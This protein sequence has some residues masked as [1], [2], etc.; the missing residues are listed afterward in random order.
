M[1]LPNFKRILSRFIYICIA[2]IFVQCEEDE[3]TQSRFNVTFIDTRGGSVNQSSGLFDKGTYLT[4]EAIPDENFCF[5]NWSGSIDSDENPTSLTVFKELSLQPNFEFCGDAVY[6]DE[7]GITIKAKE[8]ALIGGTGKINGVVYTIISEEDLRIKIENGEDLSKY[9]TSLVT[10]MSG[11]FRSS[12]GPEQGVEE[13][14]FDIN[15]WDV[16]NVTDM[17]SMFYRYRN[18]KGLDHWDVSNV[19]D[20]NF[21]YSNCLI[22]SDLS[23]WGVSNVTNMNG[24]FSSTRLSGDISEWNVSKVTDMSGMFGFDPNTYNIGPAYFDSDISEWDV[25]NVQN[26][27]NM[28]DGLIYFNVDISNWDVSKVNDMSGMF[29]SNYSFNQDLSSWNIS[30]VSNM[31]YM[32]KEAKSFD[33]D[34][35]NW[36]VSEVANMRFMFSQATAF[37]QDLSNWDVSNVTDMS[38]MFSSAESFN[39]D[40]SN[41]DVSNVTDSSNFSTDASSWTLP[42]PSFQ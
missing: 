29:S 15:N 7:N 26:M 27:S 22:N 39:Q 19:T 8:G 28:F 33:G 24:M 12:R 18:I 4:V 31:S 6:L 42:K 16:S 36:D 1:K 40:L 5:V 25:S 13:F 35:S 11:F 20:M 10:S 2:L 9:C 17:S 3:E 14:D 23:M 41:W 30:K 21:M 34:I 38:S 32:F 37:N